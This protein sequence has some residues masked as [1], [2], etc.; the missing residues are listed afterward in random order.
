MA[1]CCQNAAKISDIADPLKR[2]IRSAVTSHIEPSL[3][4]LPKK[5]YLIMIIIFWQGKVNMETKKP[6]V[7]RR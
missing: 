7:P 5:F 3:G 4:C 2:H 6:A 1:I